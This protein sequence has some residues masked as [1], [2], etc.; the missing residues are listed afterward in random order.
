MPLITQA[1]NL[2]LGE[3][4]RKL[5]LHKSRDAEF[6]HEWQNIDSSLSEADRENLHQLRDDL[7]SMQENPSHEEIVKIF[8]LG[9]IL[10][11]AGMAKYPFLPKA[12]HIIEIDMS[13]EDRDQEAVIIRGRIDILI[14][15]E[16]LWSIVI[17]TK[18]SASSVLEALPQTL[19]YMMAGQGNSLPIYGLCTNG[20][21]FIFVKLVKGDVNQYAL[22]DPF[23]IYRNAHNE[24]YDVVNILRHL[25]TI[26]TQS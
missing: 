13:Y 6:F 18:R 21:D 20:A 26:V 3:V 22:S 8:A 10:R 25:G 2:T 14:S 23:S 16:N 4:H 7:E 9:P 15:H 17:E 24:L 11:L 1:K 19:T 12:E 5:N